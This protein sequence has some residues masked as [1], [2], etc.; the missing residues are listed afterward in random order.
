MP[1]WNH[2]TLHLGS[3]GKVNAQVLKF[4]I[5]AVALQ[6]QA[7]IQPHTLTQAVI[8]PLYFQI[9]FAISNTPVIAVMQSPPC[10]SVFWPQC[11]TH[12][13]THMRTHITLP[14]SALLQTDKWAK[15]GNHTWYILSTITIIL[16]FSIHIIV[17]IVN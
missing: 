17:V 3:W 6:Y 7:S 12:T 14:W 5:P 4:R 9:S 8:S 15:Q 10:S 2:F 16:Y 13:Q 11:L 1:A